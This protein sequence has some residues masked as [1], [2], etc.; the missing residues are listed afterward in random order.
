MILSL[1]QTA[2]NIAGFGGM[3]AIVIAYGYSTWHAA[4]N[5][6][7]QHGL[8]LAGAILLTVSLL[9]NVNPA[10]LVLEGFWASIAIYGLVKAYRDRR[11]R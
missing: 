6:Y 7:A 8:N 4:P 5:P 9:V 1:S 3:A 10:S 2:A 11:K